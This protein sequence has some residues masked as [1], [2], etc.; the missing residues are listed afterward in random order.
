M[1]QIATTAAQIERADPN[2][3]ILFIVDGRAIPIRS[4]VQAK[5]CRLEALAQARGWRRADDDGTR[6]TPQRG[7]RRLF[8]KWMP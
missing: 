3:S 4:K 5:P 8:R 7:W 1:T 6:R 2:D